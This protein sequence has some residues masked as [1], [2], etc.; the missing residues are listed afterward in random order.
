ME[1]LEELMPLLVL[2]AQFNVKSCLFM[3]VLSDRSI[4]DMIS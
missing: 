4:S 3:P 2:V 1:L